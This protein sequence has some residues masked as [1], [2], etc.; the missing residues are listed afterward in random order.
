MRRIQRQRH[1]NRGKA[2][3]IAISQA[4]ITADLSYPAYPRQ[5]GRAAAAPRRD[6]GR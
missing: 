4:E 3:R 5:V 6:G 2:P 1:D